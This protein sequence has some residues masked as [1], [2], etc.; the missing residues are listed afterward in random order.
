MST[1][2]LL[3]SKQLLTF[4]CFFSYIVGMGR[5]RQ[6]K[7]GQDSTRERILQTAIRLFAERSYEAISIRDITGTLG[8][9]EAT[10]Y[11]HFKN[12]EDLLNAI[13]QRL[14]ETLI[15]PGFSTLPPEIFRGEGPFDLA[16]FLINGAERFFTS[17]E[18]NDILPTWRILM[19]N[20]YRYESA[21]NSVQKHI[22][23]APLRFFTQI[24]E[25]LKAEGRIK[26]DIDCGSAGRIIAAIFFDYS[27]RSNLD[28]AWDRI[29]DGDLSKLRTDLDFVSGGLVN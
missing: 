8:V 1:G 7:T 9:N 16:G 26:N 23:D 15:T 5:P 11:N 3:F 10:L 18:R 4:F 25:N 24:L 14:D 21:H 27:F 13:L 29:H 12:K 22:L 19:M 17:A 28:I 20:Q 6:S 2:F